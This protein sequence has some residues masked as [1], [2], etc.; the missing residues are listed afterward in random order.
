MTAVS[1]CIQVTEWQSKSGPRCPIWRAAE[2]AVYCAIKSKTQAYLSGISS[3][4]KET[5]GKG[6]RLTIFRSG[7]DSGRT[8]GGWFP[9]ESISMRE[10]QNLKKEAFLTCIQSMSS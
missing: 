9:F 6:G 8:N 1:H 10:Y 4:V 3:A 2:V 5:R 7:Y